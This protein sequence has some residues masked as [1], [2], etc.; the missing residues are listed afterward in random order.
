M[1]VIVYIHVFV[2]AYLEGAGVADGLLLLHLPDDLAH[3]RLLK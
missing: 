3:L 2:L 1:N